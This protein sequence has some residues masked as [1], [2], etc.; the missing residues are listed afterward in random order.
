MSDS[1]GKSKQ[2]NDKQRRFVEEYLIDFNGTQA[3]I[4]AGY[5]AKTARQ[6]ASDLLTKPDISRAIREGMDKLSKKAELSAEWVLDNLRNVAIRCQQAEPVK[7]WDSEKR[8]YVETGEYQFDSAGANRSLEL[9]GK[10]LGIF[11]EKVDIKVEND[12]TES[13]ILAVLELAASTK[14]SGGEGSNQVD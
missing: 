4:R 6:Q 13:E 3:A 12:A 11:K 10:H 7:V 5:S 2:L 14:A 8:E 9:L 1:E